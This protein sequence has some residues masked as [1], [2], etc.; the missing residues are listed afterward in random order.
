[1]FLTLAL[2]TAC[3]GEQTPFPEERQAAAAATV[4]AARATE[5]AV[6]Q[7]QAELTR[8]AIPSATPIPI[9]TPTSSPS[10][11][12]TESLAINKEIVAAEGGSIELSD[13]ARLEI[14]PGALKQDG[15]VSVARLEALP[16]EAGNLDGLQYQAYEIT[17]RVHTMAVSVTITFPYQDFQ[18]KDAFAP[19]AV[20]AAYWDGSEWK[21][22]KGAIDSVQKTVSVS[23]DHF[24]LWGI[25]R[26]PSADKMAKDFESAIATGSNHTEGDPELDTIM[27]ELAEVNSPV[28]SFPIRL[29]PGFRNF[30]YVP[31][32]SDI[33]ADM[34]WL[35]SVGGWIPEGKRELLL[36]PILAHELS[37]AN[38]GDNTFSILFEA[39]LQQ[40][41]LGNR[42]PQ[43]DSV[44]RDETLRGLA[45]LALALAMDNKK[46]AQDLTEYLRL[47]I[48][49][50][51]R[52]MC[53][54]TN[55]KE[56]TADKEGV[57]WAKRYIER[58]ND[59]GSAAEMG[60]IYAT[61]FDRLDQSWSCDHPSSSSRIDEIFINLRLG[62]EGG[63]YGKVTPAGAEV[64]VDRILVG[65]ADDNG[66]F[67]VT[68][69][70]PGKHNIQFS[71]A[72][73][74]TQSLPV[75][76]PSQR[77]VEATQINLKAATPT[78]VATATPKRTPTPTHLGLI[79]D[80]ETWGTWKRGDEA[81]GTFTQSKEQ[82]YAGSYSGKLTYSFPATSNNYLVFRRTISIAGQPAAL[83]IM[84]YG[85]GSGNFLNAWVQ[86]ANGQLWQF[87]FGQIYHTGWQQMSATLDVSRGWPNQAVGGNPKTAAP[88]YPLRFSALVLDG[89]REDA[90]FQ[91]V[92]YVDDLLAGD[93]DKLTP[94]PTAI[95]TPTPTS[96]ANPSISFRADRTSLSAGECTT[97]RWDVDNVTAVYLDGQ[98]VAGHESR[99]ICPTATQTYNLA[100]TRRDGS[101]QQASVTIQVAGAVATP[102]SPPSPIP[103]AGP[104]EAIPGENYGDLNI[105]GAPSDRP[106]E[107]HA[108]LNLAVRGYE[109]NNAA[110]QFSDYGPAVDPNGPQLPGLFGDQRTPR[111]TSTYQ[112]FDWDWG[113]NCRGGLLNQWDVTLLGI[114]VSSGEAI[115]V[116]DSGRSIGSGYEVLVLYASSDRITLKYT[117]DDN[118]VRGYTVHIEDV[119]VEPNLLGLYQSLNQSGR[120]RLPALRAGQAF[121]RAK[122]G[123][124]KVAIRD[125][126]A[127]FDPR[128][129]NDWWRSR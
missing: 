31:N 101:Q 60:L 8:A 75:D 39:I 1:M 92:V 72:G 9:E 79:T 106:A 20:F 73:F 23:T 24:S 68:G 116:P 28:K 113:C 123:E 65:K 10:P 110:P 93:A 35:R 61:F 32:D 91:G 51:Y 48:F 100:V 81:W 102:T 33:N 86:D 97:L 45:R 117:P 85:D 30:A 94:I 118:V 49:P 108:D 19:D 16:S 15:T 26:L 18:M 70:A 84:V 67:L 80:F 42:S 5:V 77:L 53:G 66:Q 13:G 46:E 120:G 87:T 59:R 104:C 128:S 107:S 124:I 57:L 74:Q 71:Q 63:I 58:K 41:G 56:L 78:A 83:R 99:Q 25:F 122:G 7:I 129:R 38:R 2:L 112:V 76:V 103:P 17:A 22:M 36:V 96:P 88:V 44:I 34:D 119:C 126:G 125:G 109:R 21:V 89:Y 95:N 98:G 90:P 47:A 52:D 54:T 105:Q 64:S 3:A 6:A 62:S 127:F 37:H 55:E 12:A 43:V 121:G 40:L 11:T 115:R 14:P 50:I 82:V 69:L 111:F 29:V 27:E 114:A 4:A